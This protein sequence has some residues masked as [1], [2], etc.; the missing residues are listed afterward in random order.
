MR[1]RLLSL[2]S[3]KLALKYEFFQLDEPTGR[4][5]WSSPSNVVPELAKLLLQMLRL[6]RE[7]LGRLM[8]VGRA[9][10]I[11]IAHHALFEL[12]PSPLHFATREVL[13]AIVQEGR[14]IASGSN[15]RSPRSSSSTKTSITRME[16]SPIAHSSRQS[17][18]S[19]LCPRSTLQRTAS[20]DLLQF[21]QKSYRANHLNA[22]GLHTWGNR[23]SD[24]PS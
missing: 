18:N 17:G 20:S 2:R 23:G 16:L 9:E 6:R 21:A 24:S 19:V 10:L 14:P 12:R 5:A 15:L 3:G 8:A 1:I 22:R 7:S 13:V 11:Q 4:R